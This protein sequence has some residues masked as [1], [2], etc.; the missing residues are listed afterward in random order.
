M[1]LQGLSVKASS[2]ISYPCL[3]LSLFRVITCFG[4]LVADQVVDCER[5]LGVYHLS[6]QLL[7]LEKYYGQEA[8]AYFKLDSFI[9]RFSNEKSLIFLNMPQ[10]CERAISFLRVESLERLKMKSTVL[11]I[12]DFIN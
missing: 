4:T 7:N 5:K 11:L 3:A 8:S 6:C 9:T 10:K 12:E 1:E 2:A